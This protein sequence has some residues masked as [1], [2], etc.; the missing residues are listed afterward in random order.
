[1]WLAETLG[2]NGQRAEA[3]QA[4]ARAEGCLQNEDRGRLQ[5]WVAQLRRELG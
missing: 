1:M 4:L 3:E 2:Q 5:E